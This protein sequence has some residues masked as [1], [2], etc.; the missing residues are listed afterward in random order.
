MAVLLVLTAGVATTYSD[1][2]VGFG[3]NNIQ[4][5]DDLYTPEVLSANT[6]AH[7]YIQGTGSIPEWRGMMETVGGGPTTRTLGSTGSSL[8][9][10]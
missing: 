2:A 3:S 10:W 5:Y 7:E 8:W 9:W 4:G 6:R 1:D